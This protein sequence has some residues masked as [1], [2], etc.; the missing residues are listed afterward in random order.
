M[1]RLLVLSALVVGLVGVDASA[2]LATGS[3][4]RVHDIDTVLAVRF[5]DTFPVASL[6]RATCDWAQFVRQPDG[7]GVETEH[8]MLSSEPVM[9]PAFQGQP[10][11][12][13]FVHAAGPCLWTSDY[14]FARDGSIVMASAVRYVV[15]ASGRV[16]IRAEYP[17]T[18]LDCG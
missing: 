16:N 9:I 1:R 17:A 10:P 14:W 13:A 12:S 3:V 11:A 18:P 8:C 6:M 15:S 7:S 2:A 5:D 4:D